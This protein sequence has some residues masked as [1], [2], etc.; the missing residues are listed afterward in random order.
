MRRCS[1]RTSRKLILFILGAV[2]V[3][4]GC[5]LMPAP[6][7]AGSATQ[8]VPTVSTLFTNERPTMVPISQSSVQLPVGSVREQPQVEAT[9]IRP[10]FTDQLDANWSLEQSSGV[11]YQFSDRYADTGRVAL[12]V[13]PTRAWGQLFF[14]VSAGAQVAYRRD[15]VWGLSFRLYGGDGFIATE[16]LAV[17]VIGSNAYPYWVS[18]DTSVKLEG[19]DTSAQTTLFSETR[20][21]DLGLN[22]DIPPHTWVEI[23]VEIDALIYDPKYTYLTGF[24]IKNDDSFQRTFYVDNVRLLVVP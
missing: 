12:E 20:L 6:A 11:S 4:T 16:D 7:P 18:N 17:T 22:R 3:L 23:I 19:R 5:S 9:Q 13:T 24:Y 2:F 10:I 8:P 15:E 14:T 21:Y 1:L